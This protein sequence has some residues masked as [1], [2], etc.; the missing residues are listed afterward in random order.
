MT[1]E[2]IGDE[3][4]HD[5]EAERLGRPCGHAVR[6]QEDLRQ[7]VAQRRAREGA[8]QDA[9]EGDADLDRGEEAA[10][11][12]HEV[13]GDFGAGRP[14]SAMA[15]R[16]GRRAETMASSERA[17]TPLRATRAIAMISSSNDAQE[18]PTGSGRASPLLWN[19]AL[20]TWSVW[21]GC[22]QL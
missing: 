19:D 1:M 11:I 6:G 2:Q 8:G 20:L 3:A 17:K 7:P 10:R 5:A 16:R 22:R 21:G 4:D 9:D 13:Q 14:C 15:L 18:L 12:L